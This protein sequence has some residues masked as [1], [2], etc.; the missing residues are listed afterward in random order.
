MTKKK[1]LTAYIILSLLLAAVFVLYLLFGSAK[2]TITDI[3]D[4]IIGKNKTADIITDIRLPRTLASALAG[5][6]LAISGLIL[7]AITGNELCAPNIIGINSGAGL[8]VMLILCL[9]PNLGLYTPLAAFAGALSAAFVILGITLTTPSKTKGNT[10]ILCG[11]AFSSM[12]TAV[13]SFLSLR[14]P[15]IL[16]SYT[17]FSVGGFAFASQKDILIPAIFILI[18]VI[19]AQLISSKLNLLC[20]GDEMAGTLRIS[21]R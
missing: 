12:I 3:I 19:A 16:S 1:I 14:Y 15:D 7:Q 8:G 2:L 10:I 13:I 6:A 20:L 21:V 18:S 9:V 4:G 17:A 5:A 11:V